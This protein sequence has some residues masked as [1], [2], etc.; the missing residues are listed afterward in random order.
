MRALNN[1]HV[2][3]IQIARGKCMQQA[4]HISTLSDILHQHATIK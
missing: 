1:W 3:G 2:G 4:K